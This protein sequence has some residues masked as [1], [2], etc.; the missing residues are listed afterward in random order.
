MPQNYR[1]GV[2]GLSGI[3][4]NRRAAEPGKY[5]EDAQP[6]LSSRG[7]TTLFPK[8]MWLPCVN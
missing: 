6:Q 3:A 7:P 5:L 4:A 8:P 1:V 2:V